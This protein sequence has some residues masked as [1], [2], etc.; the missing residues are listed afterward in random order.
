M[1]REAGH[2]LKIAWVEG[3][4]VTSQVNRLI[5]DR[6]EFESDAPVADAAPVIG[7][8]AWWHN[9]TPDMLDDWRALSLPATGSSSKK[10]MGM[11]FPIAEVDHKEECIK[12][13][14]R[15]LGAPS[16]SGLL[17]RSFSIRSKAL[18]QLRRRRGYWVPLL[19]QA[20]L[21]HRVHCLFGENEMIEMPLLKNTK[22]SPKQQPS[23]ETKAPI[24]LS[25]WGETVR[26]PLG[27]V[28]LSR[29]GDKA[30]DCNAGFFVR[31]DDEWD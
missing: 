9:W 18:L 24:A 17:P 3:D 11:G 6:G 30:T 8:A 31:H 22:T 1:V 16:T 2:D 27:Y 19:P 23:S 13:R 12:L 29:S 14:R 26:A 25:S 5:K 7:L 28:V 4:D 10:H 21:D 20:E 15:I